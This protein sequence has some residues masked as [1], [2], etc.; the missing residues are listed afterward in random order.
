MNSGQIFMQPA[1]LQ[2]INAVWSLVAIYWVV[3]MVLAK[4]TIKTESIPS[5][6]V[7]LV[8]GCAAVLFVWDPATGKGF[9]GHRLTS[10]ADWVAWLGLAVTMGGC[11]FAIWARATLGSNWSSMVTVKQDHELILRGPYAVVRHPIYTGFLLAL[12][13]TAIAVGE[14]RAFI[15]LGFA[16]T[17]FLWKSAAEEKFM[18]EEFSADYARY[19]QRVKRL[20]PFVF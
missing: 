4:P 17:T 11:A 14:I 20:I 8:L 18:R 5:R 16:F 3:G 12:T 1:V 10:P 9:L 6:A 13:G 19:S 15:G 2:Y 7:H